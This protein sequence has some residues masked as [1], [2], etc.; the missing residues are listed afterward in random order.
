MEKYDR[1]IKHDDV[2]VVP[3]A[4]CPFDDWTMYYDLVSELTDLQSKVILGEERKMRA[5]CEE[6]SEPRRGRCLWRRWTSVRSP[7]PGVFS[8]LPSLRS[9]RLSRLRR[10]LNIHHVAAVDSFA[11]L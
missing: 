5:G 4:F 7:H 11:L 9:S 6:R 3:E 8:A 1:K 10:D 2:I